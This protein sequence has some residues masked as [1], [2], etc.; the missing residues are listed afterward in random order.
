M[1][2]A[3]TTATNRAFWLDDTDALER[4]DTMVWRA[5]MPHDGSPASD[6]DRIT[7]TGGG[8]PPDRCGYV[9]KMGRPFAVS[10]D[11]ASM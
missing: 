2:R 10:G 7:H 9:E 11:T 5:E 3:T 1:E 4:I 6:T 8:V